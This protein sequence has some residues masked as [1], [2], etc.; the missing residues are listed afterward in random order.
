LLLARLEV[1]K[2]YFAYAA[3]KSFLVFQMDIKTSFLNGPLK[4]EVYVNQ[5]DGF[6]DPHH[7]NKVYHLKKVLYGLKQAPRAWYDE[8]SKFLIL[9][10]HGMTLCDSIGTS[11]ATKPLDVDLSRTPID[12]TVRILEKYWPLQNVIATGSENRPL[13]IE[14][15]QY[16][17]WQG[18]MLLY[19]QGTT[20][21]P[22]TTR[23]R[24][25]DDLTLEEK[26]REACDI[27]LLRRYVTKSI[28]YGRF[29]TLIVR[30]RIKAV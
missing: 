9:K 16:D 2:I 23:E 30:K 7:P 11:M 29:R 13:M 21:S 26:I 8:L 27:K 14:K 17:S 4:E 22:A 28:A 15:S 20:T 5:P 12:Q 10:K 24:T 18:C 1:V 6:V 25:L 19:I 3:Y